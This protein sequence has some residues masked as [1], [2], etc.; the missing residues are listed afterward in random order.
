MLDAP[1]PL[2]Y[3]RAVNPGRNSLLALIA[4]L[5]FA[6][7]GGSGANDAAAAEGGPRRIAVMAPSAAE[8]AVALGLQE[9]VVA[10]GDFVRW[11]PLFRDLPRIG[12]YDTPNLETLLSLR[13]DL[14]VTSRS[15]AAARVHGEI[16]RLGI[17]VLELNTTTY[18]A[19]LEALLEFGG[20]SGRED[21]ARAVADAMEARMAAVRAH[22]ADLPARRVLFVA[23][24]DPLYAAGP[25]SHVDELIRAAGGINVMADAL[26]AYQMVSLE[27]ALERMPEVIINNSDVASDGRAGRY[28]GFWGSW[29]FLPA[30]EADRVWW[31]DPQRLSIPGPRMPEMA[32]LMQRL[33]HPERFGAPA[34]GELGPLTDPGGD[35]G[36]P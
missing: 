9:R 14:L 25:G 18:E 27:S 34:G 26:G 32:E 31:V 5:S 24:R 30:V 6:S 15:E 7:C 2:D 4:L 16:R 23:G 13:V 28:A 11:P 12:S 36:A 35:S 22:S 20:R 1:S 10:V 8:M 21:E 19:S 33:I 17:D 3:L 29:D